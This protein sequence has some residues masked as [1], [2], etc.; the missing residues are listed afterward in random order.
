VVRLYYWIHH[1][2]EYERTTGVQRVVRN[3]AAAL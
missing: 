3:L 1:T 2:G